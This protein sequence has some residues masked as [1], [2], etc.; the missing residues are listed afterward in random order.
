LLAL[1]KKSEN[2]SSCRQALLSNHA[3]RSYPVMTPKF[4]YFFGQGQSEGNAEMKDLLGGK[5]ANVA[6][7]VNLG[8]PVPPRLHHNHPGLHCLQQ[9]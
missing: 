5:G 6:E 4:V 3:E 2:R 9:Q 1:Q 7:M 8:L